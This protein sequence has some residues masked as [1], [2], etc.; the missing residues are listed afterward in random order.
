MRAGALGV[1]L[2]EVVGSPARDH[3]F[4]GAGARIELEAAGSVLAG[5][6]LARPSVLTRCI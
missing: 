3:R 5:S 1:R 2:Q 6:A 4:A